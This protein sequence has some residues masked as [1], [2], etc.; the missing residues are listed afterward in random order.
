M[1]RLRLFLGGTRYEGVQF[2]DGEIY[3]QGWIEGYASLSEMEEEY[4]RQSLPY[5]IEWIDK[6]EEQK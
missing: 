3:C 4:R 1:R 2:S 6:T 5:R